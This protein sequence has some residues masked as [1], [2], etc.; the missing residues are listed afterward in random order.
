M[1][2]VWKDNIVLITRFI[3]NADFGNIKQILNQ[4]CLTFKEFDGKKTYCIRQA[5]KMETE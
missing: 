4:L 1:K 3:Y 2:T 5:R